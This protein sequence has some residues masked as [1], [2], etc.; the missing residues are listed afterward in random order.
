MEIAYLGPLEVRDGGRLVPVPGQRLQR[1]LTRLAA[2][3]GRPV[4]V[5]A[6][7]EAVWGDEVPSDPMNAMQ[8]L[9]SR[10]RR[11]LGRPGLVEQSGAGY[12]L[13]V[14]PDAVDAC[15]FERLAAAGRDQL[16]RGRH[17]EAAATLREAL[18]LWRGEPLAEE[19]ST[20]SDAVRAG[21]ED[22]HLAVLRDRIDADVRAGSGSDVVPEARALLSAHPLREDLTAL[23]MDA[24]VA[25]GRP[26]EALETYE[27]TRLALADML[28]SDPSPALQDRHLEVL[29]VSEAPATPRTNLRAPVT[30]FVGREADMQAVGERLAASRLVTVLGAGGS[31]KTRLATEVAARVADPRAATRDGLPPAPDGVWFVDLA[32]VS[33]PDDLALAVLDGL[34]IRE[35]AL[36]ENRGEFPRGEA[37][38]RVLDTLADA[39][40]LLVVDNCEHV[41]EAAADLVADVLG[42]CP[43]VRVIATSREPLGVDGEMLYP[44]PPLSVPRDASP[45][46]APS[47]DD[48]ASTPAVHLLVDRAR[49][50]G[51]DVVV[52]TSTV[53]PLVEIVRRL[54]GL[55]LA[56]ELA[57]ARLRVLSLAE[58]ADRLADRFRL[59]TGGRRTAMPRHRTLRAVVEWSWDLLTPREREVAEHFSVFGAGA[60]P[61]AVAA[62]CPPGRSA[63]DTSHERDPTEVLDVLHALVDRS[64]L[65]AEHDG[66]LTRFRMLETLREYGAE[67]L[68]EQGRLAAA[69]EAHAHFYADLVREADAHLRTADQI[70][71][72]GVLDT[73]RGNVLAALAYLG[74]TDTARTL[75]MAVQLS[76]FWLLRE[77]GQ[78]SA[79]W[80]RFATGLPG[81]EQYDTFVLAKALELISSVAVPGDEPGPDDRM[82]VLRDISDRLG[83]LASRHPLAR[84]LRPLLL[85]FGE[86]REES[87]ALLTRN[88]KEDED[89][90][91][92]AASRTI[93]LAFAENEGDIEAVRDDVEPSLA[94]WERLGDSWGISGVLAFRGQMRTMDGDLAGAADDYER[95]QE[96]LRRLGNTSD[97]LMV[98]MRLTDLRL[99][100]GDLEGAR[101]HLAAMADVRATGATRHTRAVLVEVMSAGVALVA[102]DEA[103][104]RA[105]RMRLADTLTS[106][107]DMTPFQAHSSATGH[108]MLAGLDIR[109]GDLEDAAGHVREGYRLAA[110][111]RDLPI[112]AAV[113]TSVAALAA[114]HGLVEDAAEVLGAATRLRG[115]E[116]A[117]NPLVS[118][119]V[120]RIRDVL[121][122]A[123]YEAAFARGRALDR[124][125]ALARLDPAGLPVGGH[126]R[127]R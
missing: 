118:A 82:D 15:R 119:L 117:G 73:E 55:P 79:R 50:A 110:V 72:L 11:T 74:D 116:D 127:R 113:G 39:A 92:A 43:G 101:L 126:T 70:H 84:L 48:V 23:L 93:R 29:R 77:N 25:A 5:G 100:A 61:D 107:P 85:F 97:D 3:A 31:G 114:A 6:L 38:T 45:D 46:E 108:G 28:G 124:D 60:R 122:D 125:A 4:S 121:D 47:A 30:S 16:S 27:R 2:D 105:A 120:R 86:Q 35:V 21:L 20:E 69:R 24:L 65:V 36:Y 68:V 123:T 1:L 13:A 44:L 63:G 89:P 62:V 66:S 51:A 94:E 83:P 80:L 34:G 8:S 12:R 17:A 26:A 95:S 75:E 52:D 54:D 104:V 41:V 98:T 32:S 18:A 49:A 96:A 102:G 115:A 33:D 109:L 67:R 7:A 19:T 103:G 81:A 111:T 112:V 76:W 64:L 87:L 91:V 58:V 56:I 78:D 42:R 22:L 106:V 9:V 88:V 53:A 90:W 71:W 99:R 14:E 40:S 37:R 59:L 10:L 57:A